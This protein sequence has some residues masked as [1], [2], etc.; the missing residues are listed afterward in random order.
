MIIEDIKKQLLDN[1]YA[2]CNILEHFGFYH[3]KI[4]GNRISFANS[5]DGNKTGISLKLDE[6]LVVKDFVRGHKGD[7]FSF[8][9]K[10][11]GLTF[12]EVFSYVKYELGIENF[13]YVPRVE[14]FGGLFS[15]CK[16]KTTLEY[17]TYPDDVL[18]RYELGYSKKFFDDHISFTTQDR[19]NIRYD[20]NN[21]SIVIPIRSPTGEIIG[22]KLRRNYQVSDTESKY[23]Y[24][25]PCPASQ[26]LFGYAQNYAELYGNDILVGEAEKFVMQCDSYGYRNA[27]A[28][29]S[30]SLSVTQCKLILGLSP[31][32]VTFMMD[33]GLDPET[34][35]RNMKLLKSYSSMLPVDVYYWTG[36]G[37]DDKESPTDRGKEEFEKALLNRSEIDVLC[38]QINNSRDIR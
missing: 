21:C 14:P 10:A 24:D 9:I 36:E 38:E 35:L 31:A 23:V 30:S 29:G 32:S 20:F 37:F 17:K 19:F 2:I 6:S 5:E 7:I 1:P 27:V 18:D 22:S 8:L 4:Y 34:L 13:N 3:M 15:K 33:V 12:R 11:R 26:T 25:I 28:L 16:K